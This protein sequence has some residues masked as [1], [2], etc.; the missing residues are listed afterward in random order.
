MF[1]KTTTPQNEEIAKKLSQ[2]NYDSPHCRDVYKK[3]IA[4]I[5]KSNAESVFRQRMLLQDTEPQPSFV[6]NTYAKF[7][8]FAPVSVLV[9]VIALGGVG[10][11][12]RNQ[13]SSTSTTSSIQSIPAEGTVDST[14][15]SIKSDLS[16]ELSLSQDAITNTLKT[17]D[18]ISTA[19]MQLGEVSNENSF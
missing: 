17:N 10:L 16:Q 8:S 15:N 5:S 18:S 2:F 19:A 1:R 6:N 13:S 11:V 9:I 3:T 12:L 7:K 4:E 14:V